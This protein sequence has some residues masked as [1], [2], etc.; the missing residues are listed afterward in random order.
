MK[1]ILNDIYVFL[2]KEDR[3]N[4]ILIIFILILF[5]LFEIISIASLGFL[6][7][8]STDVNIIYEENLFKKIFIFLNFKNIN[9]F[10]VFFALISI[11]TFI[12][13]AILSTISNWKLVNYMHSVGAK[14]S[15]RL[16]EFYLNKDRA[17]HLTQNKS[18]I[19]KKINTDIEIV[20]SQIFLPSLLIFS[21]LVFSSLA[22]FI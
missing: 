6:L 20:I 13:S 14:M 3:N 11:L 9:Y 21:R 4:Y 7:K 15:N 12:F 10:I 16:F 1:S 8:I 22:L 18:L 5:S 19:I 17:F 2:S